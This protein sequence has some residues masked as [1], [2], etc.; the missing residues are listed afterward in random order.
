LGY[1]KVGDFPRSIQL[2]QKARSIDGNSTV[3]EMLG[4]ALAS[5]GRPADARGVLRDLETMAGGQYVCP[6]EVATVY[7]GLGDVKSTMTWLGG[8]LRQPAVCWP[9]LGGDPNP[10]GLRALPD[11]RDM[12]R[13]MGLPDP[14]RQER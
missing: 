10:A 5:A 3:L 14:G 7:A 11:F 12:L 8:G 13:R 1:E 6:Y 9:W 4:G 2:L